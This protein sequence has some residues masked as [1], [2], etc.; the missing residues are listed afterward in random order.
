M[1]GHVTDAENLLTSLKIMINENCTYHSGHGIRGDIPDELK[2]IVDL[3][4]SWDIYYEKEVNEGFAIRYKGRL[5]Q[6]T[7]DMDTRMIAEELL[8]YCNKEKDITIGMITLSQHPVDVRDMSNKG[9]YERHTV[10]KY[11]Y[12]DGKNCVFFNP[13]YS[14]AYLSKALNVSLDGEKIRKTTCHDFSIG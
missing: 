9:Y 7:H 14:L 3:F 13:E 11:S 10:L 6:Y 2:V 4:N 12:E 8:K 1:D 5:S